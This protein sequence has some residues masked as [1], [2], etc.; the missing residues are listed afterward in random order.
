MKYLHDLKQIIEIN[1]YT[2]NKD[3][4]DKV[5]LQMQKWLE[6]I[7]FETK[8]YQ[9]DLIGD[10]LLF[11]TPKTN[12][13]KILLLGHNDTVFPFGTF[14][15][16]REDENWI[17]GPGVCDM[18]GGNI[19]ALESLRNL[20][21]TNKQITNID[22]LLVSD[23]ETGSDDSKFVTLELA[24]NYDYCF[25]FEAAGENLEVVT[26]RKGVG[27]YTISIQGVAAHA[28]TSYL[29]GTNANLEAAYKLQE[30]T[31]LTNLDIGTTVNVGQITGGIGAN[32]ISP[33]CE[34]LLEIRYTKNSER[35]RLLKALDTITNTSYVDGTKSTLSGLIQRDVMEEN[36]TQLE[37]V[38]QLEEITNTT[39]P[40]EQR[41]GVSDANHVASCGVITLDGFGPFGDGDHTINERALK[42]SFTQRISMMS[43][44]LNSI[45]G[46]N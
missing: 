16:F 27:T 22:F 44:I 15:G 36:H 12:G 3:G 33:K 42:S 43:K 28:G 38:K 2:Q 32:T 35:D 17:Y 11:T 34:L 25:V 1:S 46:E 6:D 45:K 14:E 41:G 24:K 7:G 26:S 39:I 31:K 13:P 9:R 30:L 29:K 19:V 37:F 40:R 8:R 4:V 18:K 20:H 23:E 10:H 5:G 21:K